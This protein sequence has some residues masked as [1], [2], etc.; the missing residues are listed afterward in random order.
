MWERMNLP[1]LLEP[2]PNLNLDRKVH[3][4][5]IYIGGTLSGLTSSDHRRKMN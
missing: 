4:P 1:K 5:N 3:V 2:G